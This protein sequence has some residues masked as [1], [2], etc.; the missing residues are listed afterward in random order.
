MHKIYYVWVILI[1][2]GHLNLILRLATI[3][4]NMITAGDVG[5]VG[6]DRKGIYSLASPAR[7]RKHVYYMRQKS[8]PF[9]LYL[10]HLSSAWT[11]CDESL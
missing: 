5:L 9:Y 11:R 1:L 8:W 3:M 2:A 7:C 4:T 10:V 6:D